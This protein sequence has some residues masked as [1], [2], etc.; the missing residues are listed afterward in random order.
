MD[1]RVTPNQFP[2]SR[3]NVLGV[4]VSALNLQL[5]TAAIEDWIGAGQREYVCVTGV[6]GIIESRRDPAVRAVHNAAGLVVPDGMPL[7]WLLRLAG[8]RNSGRVYGPDLMLQL[9]ERSVSQKFT[10][11]LY[12]AA[13]PTLAELEAKLKA[14]FPG[15]NIVGAFAPPFRAL[16]SAEEDKV[17]AAVNRVNP[18]IVWVGLST[19]KQEIWMA[20]HRA[21]LSAR[22]LLGVGAAFDF[23][24]GRRRQAPRWMQHSGLEWLF[25]MCQEP[26]RL[27]RRYLYNNPRFILEIIA[28]RT[29]LCEYTYD[30]WPGIHMSHTLM[31]LRDSTLNNKNYSYE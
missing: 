31:K 8:Q 28:Q 25:R 20:E 21:R 16:T 19:P 9:L 2:F 4:G 26:R 17:V 3:L 22:V 6:H 7:V 12:G 15:L 10:H 29:G 24:A 1:C 14:R 23:H 30:G 13:E 27:G 5:A 18:D 11:F